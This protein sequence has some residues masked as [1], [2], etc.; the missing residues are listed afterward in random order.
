MK[1]K[2]Q[3]NVPAPQIE[4]TIMPDATLQV[5]HTSFRD[6]LYLALVF[7]LGFAIYSNSIDC[8]FHFDDR[9]NIMENP[10]IRD[11][12]NVGAIWEHSHT[13]FLPFY[14]FA[15]NYSISELEVGSYHYFNIFIH[16]LNAGLVWWL[17]LLI[18][19]ISGLA[20]NKIA[21]SKNV[22]AFVMAL[23]FVSHP[24]ATQ[25]VTYIVQRMASMAALFYLLAVIFYLKGRIA[26]SSRRIIYY[27]LFLIASVSAFLCKENS[28]T[29]PL[30][31]LLCEVCFFQTK[32]L[33]IQASKI[34]SA[35][36]LLVATLVIVLS[37]FSFSVFESK[38][39]NGGTDYA[40]TS[41]NYLLTQFKVIPIYIRLLLFPYN[42]NLDHDIEPS[43]TLL[44]APTLLGLLFLLSLIFFAIYFFKKNRIVSFG[45]F[46]FFIALSIESS[47]KPIEDVMFEHRTYLPSFG[48]FLA[49]VGL[50]YHFVYEK[51]KYLAYFIF[52]VIIGVN[53]V[54]TYQRNNVWKDSLSLWSDVVSKSPNKARPYLN[55][56]VA[57]WSLGNWKDAMS[58]YSQAIKLNPNYFAAAYWNLGIAQSK[59]NQWPESISNFTKAIEIYP[60]Y[61]DAFQSRG[62]SYSNLNQLKE[63]IDD[64]SKAIQLQPSNASCYF[65]RGN[66]Y[67][68]QKQWEAAKSDFTKAIELDPNYTDAYCNRSN[69]F[70]N[71]NEL[72]KAIDDCSKTISINPNYQKAF[73]NRALLYTEL[74]EY[75][76][77]IADYT[78]LIQIN[79]KNP[80]NYLRRGVQYNNLKQYEN[81][82]NDFDNLAKMQPQNKYAN[83]MKQYLQAVMKK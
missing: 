80:D 27:A 2:K 16:L 78:K 66:I 33:K 6:V 61:F 65:N 79:P 60:S 67:M 39:P 4:K 30:T 77:A 47:I 51:S 5:K 68:M 42:Q 10:V 62:I 15:M 71:L 37:N 76:R 82:Y 52:M 25:S 73:T 36:G 55:R 59:F 72:N 49:L 64:L 81:A 56:G 31:I 74:K 9:N 28:F 22:I 13:R 43:F 46:W 14:S 1:Q 58:D 75:E 34:Y 53:S 17:T 70:V 44:D 32:S 7:I 24:L 20:S 21:E 26:D 83:D 45:I 40:V 69:V 57:Q 48:F 12:S 23:L 35:L 18:F 63:A 8:A 54:L 19:S 29:L 3:N 11:V 38:V 41:M 50:V